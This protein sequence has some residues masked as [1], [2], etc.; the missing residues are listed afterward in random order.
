[1]KRLINEQAHGFSNRF[2]KLVMQHD[3]ASRVQNLDFNIQ[4]FMV[5]NT[6]F[7]NI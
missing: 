3:L 1:M 7:K 2:D 6:T 5:F 4:G